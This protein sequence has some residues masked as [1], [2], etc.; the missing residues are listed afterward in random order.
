MLYMLYM[1]YTLCTLYTLYLYA[2]TSLN[3][4]V[5]GCVEASI[6]NRQQ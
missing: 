1:L 4:T 5:E 3:F 6:G 2:E